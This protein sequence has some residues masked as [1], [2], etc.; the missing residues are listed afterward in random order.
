MD[1]DII[2][3]TLI[4]TNYDHGLFDDKIFA[5]YKSSLGGSDFECILPSYSSIEDVSNNGNIILFTANSDEIHLGNDGIFPA[6]ESIMLFNNNSIDTLNIS[7]KDPKFTLDGDIIFRKNFSDDFYGLYKL[8]F[9]DS[10]ETLLIDSAY[11]SSHFSYKLSPDKQKVVYLDYSE[12][13]TQDIKIMNIYSGQSL[14]IKNIPELWHLNIYWA[15]DDYLYLTLEDDNGSY[16]LFKINSAGN[17]STFTQL[18]YFD[19]GC[20]LLLTDDYHL[21]KLVLASDSCYMD[22]T[23]INCLYTFDLESSETS[24]IGNTGRCLIPTTQAWSSANEKVAV[25]FVFGCYLGGP[26]GLK[27]FDFVNEYDTWVAI[28]RYLWWS[29]IFWI[30]ISNNVDITNVTGLPNQFRLYQ[31]YP[32]PFNPI[33]TLKYILPQDSFVDISIYD[34][35]GNLVKKLS[36]EHQSFG[37]KTVQWDAT[38][39]KGQP[40]SAGVYLY[41]IE[42]EKFRQTKKMILLK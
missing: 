18:T 12:S 9:E 23:L 41:S 31:N 40:V 17:D 27:L 22:S 32:N 15:N 1:E 13:N 25:G 14:I 39:N 20:R 38:N 5:I 42:T 36:S 4:D 30:N 29:K 8:N 3:A 35:L 10:S 28:P 37:Y 11:S 24:Y 16:Q 34:L 21:D 19:N 26:G 33:T 6:N 7:G 2:Y